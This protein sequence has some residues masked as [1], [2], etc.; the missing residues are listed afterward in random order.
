MVE[1]IDGYLAALT[2][3][4]PSSLPLAADVRV[5]ENGYPIELG[6]G[7]FETVDDVTYRH[8]VTDAEAGQAVVFSVVREGPLLANAAIRL[9]LADGRITEI[10]TVV[11]RKGG[12]SVARPD[13]LTEPNPLYGELVDVGD[14]QSREELAAIANS[15][16]EGIE[17]NTA[18][19]V[20]FHPDC[21]RVENGQ[22]TTNVGPR[23]MSAREQFDRK[24][25][26]YITR[27]RSRRFPIVDEE[28]GLVVA[29]V[30]MDVPG[31]PEHFAAFP[32]P[33]DELPA[34]MVTPRTIALVEL[35]KVE[36]GLIRAIEAAMVN[37][38]FGASSG[39]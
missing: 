18:D 25:F 38:T 4:D 12:A 15:Y 8:V 33:L 39:W 20:P 10:E 1:A 37:V 24:I 22:S 34:R 14:R 23:A 6:I 13:K 2:A 7:L 17:R 11:A 32:V 29:F 16:F 5:T 35:F 28:R 30:L 3:K 19:C 9:A 27:V 26:T 21:D 36:A 31:R